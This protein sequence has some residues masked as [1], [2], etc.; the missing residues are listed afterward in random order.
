MPVGLMVDTLNEWRTRI[1]NTLRSAQGDR[2]G[3]QGLTPCGAALQFTMSIGDASPT[4]ERY[5]PRKSNCYI[6]FL[7]KSVAIGF[8]VTISPDE[9]RIN[10]SVTEN[11]PAY[12]IV[13]TN[14]GVA[15]VIE[16]IRER[17]SREF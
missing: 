16:R 6:S 4:S 7:Y 3:P 13:K 10:A 5:S 14:L 8:A 1:G 15:D 2:G 9:E 12:Y 17:L 11:E